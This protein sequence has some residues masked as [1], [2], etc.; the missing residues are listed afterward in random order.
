MPPAVTRRTVFG[1]IGLAAK[2]ERRIEGCIVDQSHLAGHRLRDRARFAAPSETKRLP[3]VVIGGGIAGLSAGWR[4][5]KRGFRDFVIL[6]MESRPGGNSR[7]GENEVSAYPWAAHYLP[8]PNRASSLVRELCEEFG[9]LSHGQFS[10][11]HLCY[12]PQERLYLHG[13]WQDGLEPEATGSDFA[14]FRELLKAESATGE[15]QIPVGQV[16]DPSKLDAITMSDWLDRH[17]LNSPYLRWYVDYATRDDYGSLARDTS[18]WAGI[19]Y[20]AAR[21]HEDKGPLT[22]PEGNGWLV[23]RLLA[24]LDPHVITDAMVTSVRAEGSRWRVQ[25]ERTA[26]TADSVIFA[27][28]TYLARFLMENAPAT[29]GLTYSPWVTANLTL[30]RWPAE[31]N[32]EPAWDNVIYG[33]RS[34]GYVVATHQTLRTR[35]DRTVWTW[36]MA[37]AD[38]DPAA[39]RRMLLEK[40]WGY[41]RDVILADL[42]RAHP[43]IRECVSRIDVMRLGHAMVRPTPGWLTSPVRAKLSA[44]QGR[45]CFA[46]SDLS[47]LSLFEEAQYRGVTAAD[48]VLAGTFGMGG[49]VK[50]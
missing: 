15:F 43:D 48:R 10:E 11:R 34:L 36:Y 27:A 39:A 47:G 14:R 40:D 3:V 4:M 50:A 24:S 49:G 37:L 31:K 46:N 7:W 38:Q 13:R 45:F 41:W 25:T 35:V 44:M 1:L 30:D 2:A 6:E 22:W 5:R 20:F 26:Y 18:A 12:S 33:S 28:P 19:H 23:K 8:V 42:E 29:T 16:S 32:S 21:E 9:L 17:K